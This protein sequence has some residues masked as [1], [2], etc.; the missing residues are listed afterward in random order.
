MAYKDE[1][2]VARLYTDSDFLKRVAGQFEGPYEL[3]LHLAPPLLAERDPATGHLK[4]RVYGP[5]MLTAFRLLARLRG[6][7]GTRLDIFARTAE[8]RRERQLIGDYEAVLDEI[9]VALAPENRA[10]AAELA[11]L[12]L[13]IRGFGHIKEASIERAAVKQTQLLARFRSPAAA[14]AL[15]AAE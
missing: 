11:A 6:L 14:P 3:R 10:A 12:P 4:K 5:W 1:Y 2:E 15:A 13:E 8:R 9:T 7:R